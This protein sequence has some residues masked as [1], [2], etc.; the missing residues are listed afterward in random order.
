MPCFDVPLE[1]RSSSVLLQSSGQNAFVLS[2]TQAFT[3]A[4][5]V[6]AELRILTSPAPTAIVTGFYNACGG[7]VAKPT[8]TRVGDAVDIRVKMRL[9]SARDLACEGGP[10]AMR[11]FAEA[12]RLVAVTDAGTQTYTVNGRAVL[13]GF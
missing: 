8:F 12:I 10:W 13:P 4:D 11:P 5:P 2:T 6:I 7:S 3:V 1:G 9:P